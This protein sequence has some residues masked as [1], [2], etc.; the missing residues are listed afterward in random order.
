MTG[1][2]L[3]AAIL[4]RFC[5]PEW[6]TFFEVR[7]ATGFSGAGR[8]ADAVAMNCYPSRGL[9]IHGIEVKSYRNDWIRELRN[10]EKS[11]AVQ[12]YCDRWWI[13]TTPDIVKDGELPPT[14]GLLV[15]NGTGVL[16]QVVAAPKL[17]PKPIDRHFLAS[18][19]R[20]AQK[21]ASQQVPALL[22]A[23]RARM[24]TEFNERLDQKLRD[25]ADKAVEVMRKVEAVKEATGIDLTQYQP[26]K[27]IVETI[28]FAL[29]V[30]LY[31]WSGF[32]TIVNTCDALTEKI[33]AHA[34]EFNI[35]L[36]GE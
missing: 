17:T 8:S 18:M 14:W 2:D 5:A 15:T 21:S 28:K 9:E 36:K 32:S 30:D 19:L 6:S 16:R 34:K 25:R 26:S 35:D 10:P 27:K 1:V 20:S 12:V 29:S 24:K 3:N 7:D 22:E 13:V 4:R 11:A 23:E 33:R 31:G